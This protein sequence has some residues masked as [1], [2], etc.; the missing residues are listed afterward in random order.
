MSQRAKRGV[1]AFFFLSILLGLVVS[2]AFVGG[3]GR[4]ARAQALPDAGKFRVGSALGEDRAGFSG[5]AKVQV[6]TSFGAPEWASLSQCLQSPQVEAEMGFFTGVLVDGA[7][8]LEVE[9]V[10]RERDG[11]GVVVRALNGAVLGG[12]KAGFTCAELVELLHSI[13]ANAT[14]EAEKSPIYADLLEST[15]PIDALLLNGERAKAEKFV[16]FLKEFED[17]Q[18]AAVKNAEARLKQ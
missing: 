1:L 4:K 15:A 5:R 14:G 17:P 16:G 18:S 12:L 6:F 7:A 10:L 2:V 11:L 3:G 8:E 9:T 13:R